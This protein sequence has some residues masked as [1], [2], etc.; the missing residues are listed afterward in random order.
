M[1]KWW[2]VYIAGMTVER[3]REYF[4]RS[5]AP[6]ETV[7][8]VIEMFAD[9]AVCLDPYVGRFEGRD[10]IRNFFDRLGEVFEDNVH[11]MENYYVDGDTV[12]C[13]GTI[14]G[15]TTDGRNYEGV[16]VVEVMEFDDE[17]IQTLRVYLDYSGIRSE[18]PADEAVPDYRSGQ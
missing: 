2:R 14:T 11:E 4:R 17:Q 5:D 12:L 1:I 9:D 3:A 6:D 7:E 18:L 13:E 16:G 10:G 8:D 15:E